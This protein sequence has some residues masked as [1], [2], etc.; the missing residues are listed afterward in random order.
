MYYRD[1]PI[2]QINFLPLFSLSILTNEKQQNIGL[3]A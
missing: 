1:S 2:S 3:L